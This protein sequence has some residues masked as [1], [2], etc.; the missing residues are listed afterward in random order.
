MGHRRKGRFNA[1]QH[2]RA[3]RC[4]VRNARSLKKTSWQLLSGVRCVELNY[5]CHLVSVFRQPH[6]A[7]P[8]SL[9]SG[10]G[11]CVIQGLGLPAIRREAYD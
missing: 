4:L 9:F 11:P 2:A 10:L 3:S 7:L 6:V 1:L 5:L 8:A